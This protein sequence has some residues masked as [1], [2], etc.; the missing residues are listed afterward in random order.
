MI[1]PCISW[2]SN[3]LSEEEPAVHSMMPPQPKKSRKTFP[4]W[5]SGNASRKYHGDRT[6]VSKPL[7]RAAEANLPHDA[8]SSSIAKERCALGN[9]AGGPC[10]LLGPPHPAS[11]YTPP[12]AFVTMAVPG[13][14]QGEEDRAGP[15]TRGNRGSKLGHFRAFRSLLP[16]PEQQVGMELPGTSALLQGS[17]CFLPGLQRLEVTF[18]APFHLGEGCLKRDTCV[19]MYDVCSTRHQL[20]LLG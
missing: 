5:T 12:P 6:Y 1:P 7:L 13:T 9:V 2:V 19:I 16:H 10:A 4:K 20:L 18:S 15:P 17:V 11:T 3:L 8:G 14:S